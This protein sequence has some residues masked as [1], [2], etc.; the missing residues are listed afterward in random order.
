MTPD[1][2]HSIKQGFDQSIIFF[3]T[4][5]S[6]RL[7]MAEKLMASTNPT[8]MERGAKMQAMTMDMINHL[9][10]LNELGELFTKEALKQTP[11]DYLELEQ[12]LSITIKQVN[13]LKAV[14][15]M[16]TDA[17]VESTEFEHIVVN[18]YSKLLQK[19]E[20]SQAKLSILKS[21]LLESYG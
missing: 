5:L 14:I 2:I 15:R 4:Y 17:I 8:E 19:H 13:V 20:T 21:E 9:Y 10:N 3:D 11:L 7:S 1:S 16:F 12:K 18:N 6:K